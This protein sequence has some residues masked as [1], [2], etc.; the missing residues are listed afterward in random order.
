MIKKLSIPLVIYL[1]SLLGCTPQSGT[2][3]RARVE[4]LAMPAPAAPPDQGADSQN[5]EFRRFIAVRHDLVV[6]TSE[7]EL[8]D[9]WE[10][11]VEYCRTIH[12]EITASAIFRN[13]GAPPSAS[14]SLRV[15]PEEIKQLIER[16]GKAGKIIEHRTSSEDKTSTVID[17]EAKIK[18]LVELRD[19]L[20]QMLASQGGSLKDVQSELDSLQMRRKA[21]ANETEKIAVDISFRSRQSLAETGA[22]SPIARAW[23]GAGSVLAESIGLAITF[24]VAVLPWL[25]VFIPCLWLLIRGIRRL[26]RKRSGAVKAPQ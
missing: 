8:N 5:T 15:A 26:R 22:F 11:V 14:L 4:H 21:L 24:V 17:V 10:S 9:A 7:S 3:H 25:I 1:I 23:H 6:E 18:N 20:R 13:S 16:I 2:E 19:R 12:C